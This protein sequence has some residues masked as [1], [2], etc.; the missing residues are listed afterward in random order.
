[1]LDEHR[2]RLTI[3]DGR[4]SAIETDPSDLDGRR[5]FLEL[6]SSAES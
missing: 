2:Y 1:M 6:Q 5:L 4:I 3:T